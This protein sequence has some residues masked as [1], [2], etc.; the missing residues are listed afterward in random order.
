MIILLL[1]LL[2][3]PSPTRNLNLES[4]VTDEEYAVCSALLNSTFLHPKTDLAIIQAYTE[5]DRESVDIPQEFKADLLP[6]IQRSETIERRFDLRVKYVLLDQAKIET[7]FQKDLG[8]GWERYWRQYPN[9]TG[10]LAFSRVGF[11]RAHNKAY[12]YA[13]ETCGA[14]CGDGYSFVLEKVNGTWQVKEKKDLWVA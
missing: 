14:L 4:S 10:L 12:V 6:K 8:K 1:L 5:F 7:L 9:A 3:V 11:D 13:R 2:L